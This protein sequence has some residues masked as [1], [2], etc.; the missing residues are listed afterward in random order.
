MA[1]FRG[2][3]SNDAGATLQCVT[4]RQNLLIGWQAVDFRAVRAVQILQNEVLAIV[5]DPRMVT[6]HLTV[7]QTQ[8]AADTSADHH[9][10]L[11]RDLITAAAIG[12]VDH[13]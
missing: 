4:V 6:R 7:I 10:L 2:L 5:G 3:Q 9:V 1:A 13:K 12:S 8:V 11:R